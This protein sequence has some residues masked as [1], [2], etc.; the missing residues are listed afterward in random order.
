MH[1]SLGVG[2]RGRDWADVLNDIVQIVS[3]SDAV[4]LDDLSA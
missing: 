2:P 4:L 1:G 3:D